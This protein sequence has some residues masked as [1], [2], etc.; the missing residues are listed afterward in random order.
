MP[1]LEF[2]HRYSPEVV[3]AVWFAQG[4]CRMCSLVFHGVGRLVRL[5]G[6][7]FGRLMSLWSGWL[8]WEARAFLH[9]FE[10]LLLVIL[11]LVSCVWSSGFLLVCCSDL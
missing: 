3:I 8:V 2:L 6:D 9:G 1:H 5:G 10:V 11:G 4:T 7:S